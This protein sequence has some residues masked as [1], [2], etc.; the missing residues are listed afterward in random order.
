MGL[1]LG[2]GHIARVYGSFDTMS[3]WNLLSVWS[4]ETPDAANERGVSNKRYIW[5]L[6]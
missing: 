2:Q 6:E 1:D 5:I 4:E 3:E